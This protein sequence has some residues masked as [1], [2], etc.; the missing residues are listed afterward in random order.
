MTTDDAA[1][2]LAV[3]RCLEDLDW[4][5]HH[6]R[7]THDAYPRDVK[8]VMES[9]RQV[10]GCTTKLLAHDLLRVDRLAVQV[11]HT[12]PGE[13]GIWFR[14]DVM[15]NLGDTPEQ[16]HHRVRSRHPQLLDLANLLANA[17]PSTV[18]AG[19]DPAVG[20]KTEANGKHGRQRRFDPTKDQEIA[21]AWQRAHDNHVAKKDFV[22]DRQPRLTLL[23]LNR[24]LNRVRKRTGQRASIA[25]TK[26]VK[27]SN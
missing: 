17:Q 25:R 18:G 13:W 16:R 21:D 22:K 3:F 19:S 23:A 26:P 10:Q 9:F 8:L 11:L 27:P 2:V 12:P 20:K 15:G 14:K 7:F 6:L 24:L 1:F 4:A 5:C